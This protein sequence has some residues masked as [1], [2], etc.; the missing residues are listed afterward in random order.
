VRL[1]LLHRPVRYE[2]D[3]G[4]LAAM[5]HELL[6]VDVSGFEV[7]DIPDTRARN[8]QKAYSLRGVD[9]WSA[10]RLPSGSRSDLPIASEGM[11]AATREL[12]GDYRA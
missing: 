10:E 2:L 4:G 7:R 12:H 6:H 1:R 9:R 11:T 5:L 3:Q 8:D